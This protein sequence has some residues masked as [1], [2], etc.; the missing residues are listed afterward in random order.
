MYDEC[1]QKTGLHVLEDPVHLGVYDFKLE[2]FVDDGEC[3]KIVLT[4][5]LPP[6]GKT[7]ALLL[8]YDT[9][10]TTVVVRTLQTVIGTRSRTIS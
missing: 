10:D 9:D 2:N 7:G 4:T 3:G 8:N 5:L 1:S 6:G